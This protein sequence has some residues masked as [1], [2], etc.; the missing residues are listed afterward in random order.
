MSATRP[1]TSRSSRCS[2]TSRSAT[3]SRTGAI[4]LR[5][6]PVAAGVR[7]RPGADIWVT[8][9]A[10]DE[11]LGLG[12][13]EEAIELWLVGRGPARADRRLCPRSENFWEAGPVGPAG[14]AELPTSTAACIR[15]HPRTC[16]GGENERFLEYWNLVFMQ[17][18]QDPHDQLRALPSKN[19]DTGIGLNR[20]AAIL[21]GS[22]RCSRPTSSSR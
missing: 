16:P 9:F 8:V 2:A 12:P 17:Y 20:M 1:A 19:I 15:R 11:R 7:L 22:P 5:M 6:A 10:G 3:T 4:D 14:R 21:Q 18:D 13:D